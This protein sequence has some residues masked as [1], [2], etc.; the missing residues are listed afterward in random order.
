MSWFHNWL[1]DIQVKNVK[2]QT[3]LFFVK[4]R[5]TYQYTTIPMLIMVPM[6]TPFNISKHEWETNMESP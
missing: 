5:K 4:N 6:V 3:S 1:F 2:F